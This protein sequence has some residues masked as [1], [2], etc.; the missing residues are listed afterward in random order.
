MRKNLQRKCEP[1][2]QPPCRTLLVKNLRYS[3]TGVP[4]YAFGLSLIIGVRL[5]DSSSVCVT[6]GFAEAGSSAGF[7]ISQDVLLQTDRPC[8]SMQVNSQVMQALE[9]DLTR[10]LTPPIAHPGDVPRHDISPVCGAF[11]FSSQRDN[12]H[13]AWGCPAERE[14]TPGRT[15]PN[16][17]TLKG[18]HQSQT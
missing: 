12:D 2:Q 18:L 5:L 6:K 7:A 10:I 8:R 17:S 3:R 14:A 16:P 13:S 11:C 4:R 15:T 1:I 9:S